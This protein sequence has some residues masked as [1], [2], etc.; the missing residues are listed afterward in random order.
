MVQ[1]DYQPKGVFQP[2]TGGVFYNEV[3]AEPPTLD[4]VKSWLEK[5]DRRAP[6]GTGWKGLGYTSVE[7]LPGLGSETEG[8][9]KMGVWEDASFRI[10]AITTTD[11]VTVKPV[12]WSLIPIKHRFGA[13]AALDETKGLITVPQAYTPVEVA[14]LVMF[15]DGDNP[16]MLHFYRAA[17]APDGDLEADREKFM[18][19]PL[20]YT[21]LSAP[22][23]ASKM[24]I[25]GYHLQKK[26]PGT[27]STG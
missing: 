22:G 17:S 5:G 25:L 23:K 15:L 21:L 2:G 18:E 4:E 13:G 8:G 16:L 12:Q 24:N 7:D 3:G 10:S 6:I 1:Q 14:L 9:E 27:S 19:L 11:T 20:K 26:E